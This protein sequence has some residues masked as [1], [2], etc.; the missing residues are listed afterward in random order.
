M[1]KVKKPNQMVYKI[2][3]NASTIKII[4]VLESAKPALLLLYQV[5][6]VNILKS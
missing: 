6:I 5:S 2:F 4:K 1:D 3:D